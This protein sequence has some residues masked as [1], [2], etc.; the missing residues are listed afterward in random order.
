MDVPV[1]QLFVCAVDCK[2]AK[3]LVL[4]TAALLQQLPVQPARARHQLVPV[5]TQ[6]IPLCTIEHN[7][8]VLLI[9]AHL[10]RHCSFNL[11]AAKTKVLKA[12]E[13][14]VPAAF[15]H[16]YQ[17]QLFDR[18]L[19]GLILYLCALFQ[20]EALVRCMERSRQQHLEGEP[21]AASAAQ[22]YLY[23]NCSN[24]MS[25]QQGQSSKIHHALQLGSCCMHTSAASTTGQ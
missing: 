17:G 19:H 22:Q 9:S 23:H 12:V 1:W 16:F 4:S 13:E 8:L 15:V 5:R 25:S 21:A 24:W 6:H 7:Q 10:L 2:L 20:H 3:K 14:S 18:L 11:G